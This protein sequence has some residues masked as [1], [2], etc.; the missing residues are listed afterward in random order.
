[1]ANWATVAFKHD[2]FGRRIYKSSSSATSIDAYDS[3]NL[4]EETNSGESG[5][6][7][8]SCLTCPISD[9]ISVSESNSA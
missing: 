3:D 4:I 9:G 1:V 8:T 2:R 5:L 7:S 6:G